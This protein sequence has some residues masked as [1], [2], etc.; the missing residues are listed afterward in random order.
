M[1]RFL[2]ITDNF[3]PEFNAPASRTFD[4]IT[5][6]NKNDDIEITVLTCFPNF[7]FGKIYKGYKNKFYSIEYLDGIRVIRVWS[8]SARNAGT[9][10]RILDFLSFSIMSFFIGTFLDFDLIIATSPQ[11]FTTWSAF[12]LSKLKRVPW[13]FELRDLW[14]ETISTVNAINNKYILKILELIELYLYKDCNKVIALTDSF[15]KNLINRGIESTKIEVIKNGVNLELFKENSSE[16][17][18]DF[19]NKLKDKFLIA[20]IGTHGMTHG[21]DFIV[22]SIPRLEIDNIHFIFLGDGATKSRIIH[23]A[24]D[25]KIRNITFLDPVEKHNIPSYYSS[26]DVA[27]V[28]L[29]RSKTF[30]SVIP[31]KIFEACA[32]SRPILFGVEGESKKLIQDYN[33]GISFIPE[34]FI[35]FRESILKLMNHDVYQELQAG[36]KYLSNDFNR[37][38]LAN[39][40]LDTLRVVYKK[41]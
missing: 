6:W 41:K 33:A 2:F 10:K 35:T 26:I 20:Y 19:F 21:L 39:K 11:F 36:C 14:P 40:M 18:P 23:L 24:H 27:L 7:P 3:P 25:L 17:K 13:F 32:L 22:K 9:F 5:E 34:D 37:V 29:R 28:C 1:I 12:F 38:N 16:F 31:S 8:Y 15:K 4:H 30:R